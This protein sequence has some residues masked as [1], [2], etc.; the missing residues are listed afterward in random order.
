MVF[1]FFNLN[2][3]WLSRFNGAGPSL[4]EA[5]RQALQGAPDENAP[6]QGFPAEE[7][8]ALVVGSLPGVPEAATPGGAGLPAEKAPLQPSGTAG[9][10]LPAALGTKSTVPVRKQKLMKNLAEQKAEADAAV[11]E[12]A[13]RDA[14]EEAL[15]ARV[16][17]VEVKSVVPSPPP[18]VKKDKAQV[19]KTTK[20]RLA[21]LLRTNQAVPKAVKPSETTA[22]MGFTGNEP[23]T[24]GNV[25]DYSADSGIP[26]AEVRPVES[27]KAAPA[28]GTSLPR[29]SGPNARTAAETQEIIIDPQTLKAYWTLLNP[30]EP[31]P[32]VDFT[33]YAV[34][35]LV[36]A[37]KPTA[38]WHVGIERVEET[39]SNIVVWWME[40][41]PAAEGFVAQ[42]ISRPW[43]LQ[44]VPK[45]VK[46]V[47]FKKKD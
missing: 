45:P 12:Q 44:V 11:E 30:G 23:A 31:P 24:A 29:W 5:D 16:E 17:G 21:E 8:P 13:K 35:M 4:L 32:S 47:I 34:V 22:L 41:A 6:L 46:P 42:V 36:S 39:S 3:D 7:T 10:V 27:E 9:K 20:G 25:Q 15:S 38:G 19:S 43:T 37:E 2:P 1:V 18:A 28:A 14:R 33:K 26:A 40:D